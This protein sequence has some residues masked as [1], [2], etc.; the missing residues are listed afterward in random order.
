MLKES[1]SSAS[2]TGLQA[3]PLVSHAR[4]DRFLPPPVF[5]DRKPSPPGKTMKPR[6]FVSTTT[7]ELQDRPHPHQGNP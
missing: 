4:F 1:Q 7:S 2:K 3:H 6:I 5:P